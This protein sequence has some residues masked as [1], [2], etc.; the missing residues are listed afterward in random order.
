MNDFTK[1]EL[2]I[3]LK[4]IRLTEIDHGECN[5]LDNVKFKVKSKIDNY[6]DHEGEDVTYCPGLYSKIL[7]EKELTSQDLLKFYKCNKCGEFYR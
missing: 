4:C 1:E 3:L 2:N 5:D 6:C 7:A